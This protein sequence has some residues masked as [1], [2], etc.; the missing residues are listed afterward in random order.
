M[1]NAH[2]VLRIGRQYVRQTRIPGTSFELPKA[3]ELVAWSRILDNHEAVCIVNPNGVAARGA[4]V[5]VS[6]EIGHVGTAFTV[7]ANTAQ[8][9]VGSVPFTDT[10][11]VRSKVRAKGLG[12]PGEPLFI[13]IRDDNF[14]FLFS[15]SFSSMA[16]NALSAT[17][18][19]NDFILEHGLTSSSY[20]NYLLLQRIA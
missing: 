19:D 11:S 18:D 16:S 4:D 10:H 17:S 15:E 3:S 5:V 1:R 2:P 8:A 9:A 14:G 7:K 13:E 6:A 12:Q 20:Q